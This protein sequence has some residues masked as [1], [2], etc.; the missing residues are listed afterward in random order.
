MRIDDLASQLSTTSQ[1]LCI[2]NTRSTARQV[3]EA[4]PQ[5]GSYH[6]STLM[7]PKHRKQ[8]LTV[9]RQRLNEGLPCRVISTCLI[10]AGVDVD[11][12]T[13]WR[14]MTGLDSIL[15][16]AG[17]CNREGKRSVADST[18]HLFRLADTRLPMQFLQPAAATE[19]VLQQ[20]SKFDT[21][22]A[23]HEYF[24]FLLYIHSEQALDEQDILKLCAGYQFKT[25]AER[26]HIIG[27]DTVAVIIPDEEN[28]DDLHLL[29]QNMVTAPLMRRLAQSS[30]NIYCEQLDQLIHSGMISEVSPGMYVLTDPNIYHV[31]TGLSI[32]ASTGCQALMI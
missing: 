15:Q 14:E 29:Y 18:V 32:T 19:H 28:A 10:E 22:Q 27:D 4:L 23:I 30:V 13:V 2:V 1:V 20:Y 11:F 21:P 3:F 8:T 6:L 24:R 7:T 17:R 25:V 12:P 9:I 16:A 26:F 5:D 31:H